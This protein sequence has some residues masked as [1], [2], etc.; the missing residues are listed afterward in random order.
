M[1]QEVLLNAL[2]QKYKGEIAM[3]RANIDVYLFNSVGIGEHP[4]ITG[5]IDELITK[6]AE[7]DEKL[8]TL[9]KFYPVLHDYQ[10]SLDLGTIDVGD[11]L[12]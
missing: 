10:S 6:L 11:E 1:N 12:L 7:A 4:D 9:D 8:Q 5:A 3:I 2:R